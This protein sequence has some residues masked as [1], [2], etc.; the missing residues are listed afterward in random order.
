MLAFLRRLL[1][2]I[3]MPV[4]YALITCAI[5][6]GIV[7]CIGL[8]EGASDFFYT[9]A[10]YQPYAFFEDYQESDSLIASRD[11]LSKVLGAAL[12]DKD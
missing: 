8:P 2:Y 1:A 5:L 10:I 7:A 9:H 3:C 11:D 12:A 6:W 4:I